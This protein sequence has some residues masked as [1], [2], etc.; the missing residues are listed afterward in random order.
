MVYN[1]GGHSVHIR[2]DFHGI[3]VIISEA[4]LERFDELSARADENLRGLLSHTSDGE[5]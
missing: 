5:N 2:C 1:G 3:N 4:V